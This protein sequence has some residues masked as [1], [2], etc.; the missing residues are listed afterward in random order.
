MRAW[1][2]MRLRMRSLFDRSAVEQELDAELQFHIEKQIE[3]NRA[4]GLSNEEARYSALRVIGPITQFKEECREMRG[5]TVIEDWAQDVR[6]GLRV[7]L[8]SPA[9]T[10]VAVLSLA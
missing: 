6:Y 8:R 7:L 4:A 1:K 3:E 5:L 9:F 10:A 2:K